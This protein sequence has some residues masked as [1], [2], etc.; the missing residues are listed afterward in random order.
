MLSISKKV[1]FDLKSYANA[2]TNAPQRKQHV[3][4]AR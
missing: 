2:Q 3:I 4:K 1:I